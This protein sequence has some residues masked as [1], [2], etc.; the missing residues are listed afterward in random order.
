MG[1]TGGNIQHG[2]EVDRH[3][4]RFRH[5]LGVIQA[6]EKPTSLFF[7]SDRWILEAHKT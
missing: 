7:R 4:T 2:N 6:E 5:F 1:D 3:W